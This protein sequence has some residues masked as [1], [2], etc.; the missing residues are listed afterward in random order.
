[1]A[2]HWKICNV[3]IEHGLWVVMGGTYELVGRVAV[4]A[5]MGVVLRVMASSWCRR[6]VGGVVLYGLSVYVRAC[7]RACGNAG[8]LHC[9]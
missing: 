6:G 2:A 4:G 8:M 5:V 7:M 3:D 1:M 9:V